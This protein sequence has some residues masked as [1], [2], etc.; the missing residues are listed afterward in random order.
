MIDNNLVTLELNT[1]NKLFYSKSFKCFTITELAKK[2]NAYFLVG[3]FIKTFQRFFNIYKASS[4]LPKT[5]FKS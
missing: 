1:L 3:L 2:Q 5:G 4:D